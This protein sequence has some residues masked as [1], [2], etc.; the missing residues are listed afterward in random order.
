M[1]S[2]RHLV[3]V[4]GGVHPSRNGQSSSSRRQTGRGGDDRRG[5][6][7]RQR[8]QVQ[9]TQFANIKTAIGLRQ[10]EQ[11]GGLRQCGRR[12]MAS[13]TV[14]I[15]RRRRRR[16]E[17]TSIVRLLLL[18]RCHWCHCGE[19]I[20]PNAQPN[21]RSLLSPHCLRSTTTAKT[22][23]YTTGD[24]PIRRSLPERDQTNEAVVKF[25]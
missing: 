15:G 12:E 20:H 3:Q 6:R 22:N 23:P 19:L 16:S 25:S 17:R 18:G 1:M 7:A 14:H 21:Q 2:G 10:F 11:R 4:V 5:W 13:R 8:R 24:I 9:S